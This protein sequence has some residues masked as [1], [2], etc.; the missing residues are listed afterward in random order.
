MRQGLTRYTK[1]KS[2]RSMSSKLMPENDSTAE[3][4]DMAWPMY[5]M[6]IKHVLFIGQF[7][8]CAAQRE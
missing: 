4:M 1:Q 2:G 8:Q 5:R 3:K 6:G 7:I